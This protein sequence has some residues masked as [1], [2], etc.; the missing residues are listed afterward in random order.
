MNWFVYSHTKQGEMSTALLAVVEWQIAF[1]L[2]SDFMCCDE[3]QANLTT[4]RLVLLPFSHCYLSLSLS[5]LLVLFF[6]SFLCPL[7][8]YIPFTCCCIIHKFKIVLICPFCFC[9][10]YKNFHSHCVFCCNFSVGEPVTS[11]KISDEI[12][13]HPCILLMLNDWLQKWLY[14][15]CWVVI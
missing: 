3:F 1:S 9:F 11:M 10:R 7:G 15:M 4:S 6:V 8:T 2:C 5:N 13:V 12:P 14:S